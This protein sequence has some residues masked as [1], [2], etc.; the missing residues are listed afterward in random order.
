MTNF[1][2]TLPAPQSQLAKEILKDPYH[3]EFLSMKERYDEHD[4]ED[5]LVSNVTQ[6]LLELGKGFSYV[7]RQMELQMPCGQIFFP[8]LLF[9]HVPQHRYVVIELKVVKFIP[10]FA[11]KLN[12]YVT[13][14]DELLRGE[15]DN[16]TVGL[17]ICKSTDKTVVEWSL[18]DINKPLGVS[19]YQL[20]QV[21]E[22]TVKELELK[23]DNSRK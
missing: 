18:R 17:I 20:E 22:R 9:Y 5:A 3:F 15:G 10:E 8:D 7:G 4:L 6:F 13:A 23:K 1:E 16:P 19:S 21:V 12:F 2:Q 14:V 11:G